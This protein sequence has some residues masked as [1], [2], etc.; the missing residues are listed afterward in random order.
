MVKLSK[1]T[2]RN[3]FSIL[4][5]TKDNKLVA[6][7]YKTIVFGF[8]SSPFILNHVIQHHVSKY[9]DDACSSVLRSNMYVDNLFFTGDDVSSLV[10]M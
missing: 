10:E 6:Y 2:D 8:V 7:R 5:Q 9:P 4:W 3:K 1:E